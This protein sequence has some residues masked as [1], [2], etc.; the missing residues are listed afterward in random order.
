MVPTR[1]PRILKPCWVVVFGVVPSDIS[2][3]HSCMR[4]FYMKSLFN[5][6]VRESL[7]RAGVGNPV[8]S[9]SHFNQ[10][11]AEKK[12]LGAAMAGSRSGREPQWPGARF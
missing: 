8:C 4:V 2:G 5:L 9:K 10:F 12:T 6:L 3:I 11:Y 7:Y 1:A